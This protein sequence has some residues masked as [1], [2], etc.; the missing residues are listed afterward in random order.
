MQ[1]T[2]T[3]PKGVLAD[4]SLH[5]AELQEQRARKQKEITDMMEKQAVNFKEEVNII[6]ILVIVIV[7]IK[8]LYCE[9]SCPV[10]CLT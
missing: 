10:Y 8:K 1:A 4:Y 6:I 9:Q 7:Y 5:Q 2:K 3:G